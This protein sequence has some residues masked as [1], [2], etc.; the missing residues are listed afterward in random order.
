MMKL[1]KFL[2]AALVGAAPALAAAQNP[3]A[4]MGETR[5]AIIA[6]DAAKA[7]ALLDS[8]RAAVPDH[9]NYL[10]LRAHA[11]AMAG[12][13]DQA[14]ADIQQLLNWDIRYARSA[15]RDTTVVSLRSAFAHVDSLARIADQPISNG[16][17]WA[18]V[19]E[20]DLVPEG[21]GWDPFTRSVL[22]GSLNKYK[23]VAIAPDGTVTDRVA[24]GSNGLRSV[25]GIHV[26]SARRMLWVAS[27]SRFDTPSDSTPS[28]LFGFDPATGAFKTQIA[29]PGSEKH[30]LNDITT[31]R[32]GT[33]YV[34]DSQTG[35]VWFAAP[36]ATQLSELTATGKLISPNGITIST[37]GRV[38]FVA[39]AD[40]VQAL[41]IPAGKSW[42]VAVP[43]SFNV[44]GIDGL[45]FHGRSLI[46]HHPISY[47]RLVRYSLDPA[48]QR[49]TARCVIDANTADVRTSTTGEIAGNEYIYIGNSQIDRMNAKTIDAA[50]M[51]P[52]RI[53]RAGASILSAP[54]S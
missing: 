39:D 33:V 53:Y 7:F 1:R 51:D 18:T 46:A 42:R 21:T 26:D 47:S 40:H 34:T 6:K 17:T 29:V 32:D 27:N 20:R 12:R 38:L 24:P 28:A 41:D 45:A 43:G 16:T 52:V 48:W 8:I 14:K 25:A 22:I 35:R 4:Q 31:G 15:L 9:P 30:F 5:K 23:I 2:A 19:A 37:D 44:S 54:C 36:G 10:Y 13:Y 50:T 11:N 3:F 49:I